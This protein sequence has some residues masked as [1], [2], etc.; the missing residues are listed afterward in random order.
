MKLKTS[1][2]GYYKELSHRQTTLMRLKSG[3]VQGGREEVQG[4]RQGEGQGGGDTE[5]VKVPR[6]KDVN[7]ERM[8]ISMLTRASHL[9]GEFV[10][11]DRWTHPAV[12]ML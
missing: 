7:T 2:L 1:R 5:H 8:E 10:K 3:G 12:L 11:T 9:L 4:G 6:S